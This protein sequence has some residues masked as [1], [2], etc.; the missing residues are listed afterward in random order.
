MQLFARNGELLSFEKK[1]K[2]GNGSLSLS[3]FI[4][5]LDPH[6]RFF[7]FYPRKF[8]FFIEFSLSTDGNHLDFPPSRMTFHE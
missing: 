3:S 8:L 1:K 5:I 2:N 7:F 4:I 6:P